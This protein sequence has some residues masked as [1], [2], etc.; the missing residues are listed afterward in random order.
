MWTPMDRESSYGDKRFPGNACKGPKSQHVFQKVTL[1]PSPRQTLSDW[2]SS[3]AG[4][5]PRATGPWHPPGRHP[6]QRWTKA[7][8]EAQRPQDPHQSQ[9]RGL[10]QLLKGRQKASPGYVSSHGTL[11][12]EYT[13]HIVQFGRDKSY[14]THAEHVFSNKCKTS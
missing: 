8:R 6:C 9:A 11:F 14:A 1:L 10:G 12:M 13:H 2:V 4:G 3:G 7:D 5:T